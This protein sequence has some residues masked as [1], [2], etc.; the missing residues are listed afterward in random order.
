MAVMLWMVQQT[1]R[2]ESLHRHQRGQQLHQRQQRTPPRLILVVILSRRRQT[3]RKSRRIPPTRPPRMPL[4]P[5]LPQRQRRRRRQQQ[6]Q[7][8]LQQAVGEIRTVCS[9]VRYNLNNIVR[10]GC[11]NIVTSYF[12]K[13]VKKTEY[14]LK[15]SGGTHDRKVSAW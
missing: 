10:S 1:I 12:V 9:C 11:Y 4:L 7:Q 5:L 15:L 6:L 14:Q 13:T 8:Q 2:R 3:H